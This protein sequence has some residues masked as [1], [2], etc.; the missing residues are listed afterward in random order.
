VKIG[1]GFEEEWK[2]IYGNVWGEERGRRN[3]IKI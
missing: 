2:S 1:Y 3:V